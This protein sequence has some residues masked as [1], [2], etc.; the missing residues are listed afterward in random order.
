M[1]SSSNGLRLALLLPVS[2]WRSAPPGGPQF[3]FGLTLALAQLGLDQDVVDDA[4]DR[5]AEG[6]LRYQA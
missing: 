1:S 5:D 4:A 3:G 2:T 6:L